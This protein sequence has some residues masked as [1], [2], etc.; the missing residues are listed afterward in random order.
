[1]TEVMAKS[2][3]N[4]IIVDLQNILDYSMIAEDQATYT[5]SQFQAHVRQKLDELPDSV[6]TVSGMMHW[7]DT[8]KENWKR[9]KNSLPYYG[10]SLHNPVNDTQQRLD[11]KKSIK[12]HM[13]AILRN[14]S[15]QRSPHANFYFWSYI[16]LSCLKLS[17]LQDT[18][19]VY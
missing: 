8:L 7:R 2:V 19:V 12:L 6:Q 18:L 13:S 16:E 10:V 14:Q 1:M 11:M 3:Q 17:R 15:V 9:L 4:D 5:L